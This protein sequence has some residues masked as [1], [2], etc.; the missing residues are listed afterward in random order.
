MAGEK[1]FKVIIDG[2]IPESLPDKLPMDQLRLEMGKDRIIRPGGTSV[3]KLTVKNYSS[4][5]RMATVVASF[6]GNLISVA[7]PHSNVYVGPGGATAIYAVIST[8]ATPGI[9]IVTFG[10]Q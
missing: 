2:T 4:L 8:F 7:I 10:L 3:V 1:A 6:D 9:V 5:G